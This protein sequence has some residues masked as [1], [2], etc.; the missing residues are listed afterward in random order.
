MPERRVMTSKTSSFLQSLGW[1]NF[2][3]DQ[4]GPDEADLVPRRIASVHR[5]ELA[6]M[7]EDGPVALVL[8]PIPIPAI[9]RLAT[10]C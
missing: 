5:T 10:G 3:S 6:V 9:S 8:P 7:S 2:F 4:L 1:S